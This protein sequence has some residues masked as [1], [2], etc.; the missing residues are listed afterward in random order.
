MKI[1]V[2]GANGLLG[3]KLVAL[4]RDEKNIEL[5]ATG[6]GIN[7]NPEGGHA[8]LSADLQNLEGI[9]AFLQLSPPDA[10]IHC[11]AMTQVDEC[12]ENQKLCSQ[13][14][15]D[16]TQ[17]LIK[18][19]KEVG[20]YFLYLSTDFVFDG[21]TGPYKESDMA[22]PISHY[23]K[24]KLASEDLLHRSGLSYA[25]VR[26][27]LVYGVAHDPSRSNLVLW[28]K[29]SLEEGKAIK[30]VNDQWRTPTLAED[31]ARGC[32]LVVKEKHEGI[33]HISGEGM[34]S[35]YDMALKVADHFD[36]DKSLITPVDASTFS[37]AGKR[38]P[39]T[40]FVIEK[41]KKQLGYKPM[42]FDEGLKEVA[43][44]LASNQ[45]K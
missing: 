11:A 23:G 20:A 3:Q 39:K 42:S 6:R 26:T 28:V 14:N 15:V 13:I 45:G 17:N 29:N 22:M 2:T 40:G 21:E 9:R 31:L 43:K 34:M 16:A 12:E 7:R 41:A 4:L 44:Q 25:I 1:L 19:A 8:Y 32:L 37:Q 30:V 18:V 24:T 10:I 33:F 27:V 5:I 35:P 36:L 38:P